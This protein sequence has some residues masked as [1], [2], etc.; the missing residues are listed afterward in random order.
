MREGVC[1][2]GPLR[3]QSRLPLLPHRSRYELK[4]LQAASSSNVN[5]QQWCNNSDRRLLQLILCFVDFTHAL[6]GA[7]KAILPYR[8]AS[9]R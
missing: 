8:Q 2:P 7:L 1:V 5:P 3:L 6:R 9:R 4:A